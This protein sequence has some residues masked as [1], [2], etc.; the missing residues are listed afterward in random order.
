[1]K[2]SCEHQSDCLKFIQSVLDGAASEQDLEKLKRNLESCQPCI[3]MYHLEKE[4]KAL[5]QNKMEKRCCPER[6]IEDIRSRIAT[7]N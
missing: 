4:I 6:I 1:M 2:H 7:F 3:K 5:L